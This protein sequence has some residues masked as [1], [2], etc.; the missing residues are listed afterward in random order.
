MLFLKIL[1]NSQETTCFRV[2]RTAT[3]LKQRLRHQCFFV[4]FAKFLRKPFFIEHTLRL[5]LSLFSFSSQQIFLFLVFIHFRLYLDGEYSGQEEE[6][7]EDD[8]RSTSRFISIVLENSS[9][10][11]FRKYTKNGLK[12]A[13]Y[14]LGTYI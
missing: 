5:V 11:N 1:K 12:K 14:F 13:C 7:E 10:F 9:H 4:N 3:L 2:S 8:E 6:E